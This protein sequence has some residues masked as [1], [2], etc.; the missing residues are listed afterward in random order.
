MEPEITDEEWERLPPR[1]KLLLNA[2]FI[3]WEECIAR[4]R[5]H[6]EEESKTKENNDY[7]EP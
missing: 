3:D 7:I 1:T 4:W 6:W 2:E 5:R